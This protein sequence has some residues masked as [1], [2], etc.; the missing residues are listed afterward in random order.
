IGSHLVERL[1][2]DG[3]NV[4]CL[5]RP[6]SPRGGASRHLPA[7]GARPVLG[8]LITGAGL[9][10]ALDGVGIVFHLAG[11]TKA[12][13]ASDYYLGN[14]KTTEN[15]LR[16][17]SG[18]SATL[19]HVSSLAAVGPSRDAAPL[20]ED[21]EPRPLTHYGKSKLQGEQ[22]VRTCPVSSRAIVIRP[23][24]VYGPRDVDVYQVFKAVA[25]GVLVRIGGPE[26]YFSFI[27]VADL[28]DG[29]ILAAENR[30]A[31]GK[32]YF[33]SNPAAVS[34]T[35]FSATAAATMV[36]KLRIFT[37]PVWAAYLAGCCGDLLSH[38]TGRPRILC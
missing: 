8:D 1:L 26:S 10:A 16:A 28:V 36:R 30:A 18:S 33:L 37:L 29:L 13:H 38:L 9:D 2:S 5:V 32:T 11:V 14:V 19:V 4:R 6:T 12:L 34:W 22:A 20:R 3:A 23:P 31:A 25:S 21:A 24:V 17:M 15:L 35:E 27:Y 7:Q